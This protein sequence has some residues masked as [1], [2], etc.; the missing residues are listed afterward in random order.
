MQIASDKARVRLAAGSREPQS[1][2]VVIATEA[3][4]RHW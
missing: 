2:S 3:V 1:D 4:S